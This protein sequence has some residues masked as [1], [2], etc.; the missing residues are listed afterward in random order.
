MVLEVLSDSGQ[1]GHRL[2]AQGAQLPGRA[3][4]GQHEQLRGADRAR[5]HDDLP[6]VVRPGWHAVAEVADAGAAAVPTCRPVTRQLA[7]MIRLGRH[8]AGVR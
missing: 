2:D 3:D 6:S 1:V 8:L 4:A 7:W 5:A